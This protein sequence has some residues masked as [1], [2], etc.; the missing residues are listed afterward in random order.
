MAASYVLSR[1]SRNQATLQHLLIPG[2]LSQT[3]CGLEIGEWSRS[4]TTVKYTSIICKRC[5][6]PSI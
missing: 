6:P 1:G 4:Y 2:S 5:V 3:A